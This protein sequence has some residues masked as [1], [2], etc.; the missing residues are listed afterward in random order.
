MKEI[1]LHILDIAENSVAAGATKVTIAVLEDI[2]Y[3]RLRLCVTD[4]GKGIAPEMIASVLD[5]FTTSRTTRKVGLGIPLLKAAAEM[6]QGFL[7]LESQPGIGTSLTVEFKRNHIDRMPMGDLT[8][9]IL[10]LVISYPEINW[11]FIYA[12]DENEFVFDDQLLKKEL[13]GISLT[14]PVVLS[15]IRQEIESGYLEIQPSLEF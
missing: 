11:V 15:F 2:A 10:Q 6:C 4:N 1:S 14:E 8:G 12:V 5:P 13:E 3:D 7:N 9:T